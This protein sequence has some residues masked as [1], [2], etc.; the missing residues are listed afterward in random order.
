MWAAGSWRIIKCGEQIYLHLILLTQS[1]AFVRFNP[2]RQVI[3]MMGEWCMV[4]WLSYYG[5]LADRR[6]CKVLL[7]K[8]LICVYDLNFIGIS[9]PFLATRLILFF[10]LVNTYLSIISPRKGLITFAGICSDQ[11]A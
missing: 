8:I 10:Q 9:Y 11:T 6:L 1:R 2:L 5:S 3:M 7:V 4:S